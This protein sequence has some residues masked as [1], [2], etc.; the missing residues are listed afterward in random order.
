M[1]RRRYDV[2][3]LEKSENENRRL[4]EANKKLKISVM[5]LKEKVS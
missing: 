3:R 2:E 4:V 1:K 5:E